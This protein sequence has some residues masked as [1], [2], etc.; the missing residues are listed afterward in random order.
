MESERAKELLIRL[1]DVIVD[2]IELDGA[3]ELFTRIG[4]TENELMEIVFGEN[5][6]EKL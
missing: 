1:V 2:K 6:A 3:T 5:S 4:F